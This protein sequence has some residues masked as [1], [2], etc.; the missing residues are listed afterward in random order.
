MRGR[1]GIEVEWIN[2]CLVTFYHW[3]EWLDSSF[4]VFGRIG[5]IEAKGIS[6]GLSNDESP[7]MDDLTAGFV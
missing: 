6:I 3:F 7:M 1:V 2:D 4:L 5:R